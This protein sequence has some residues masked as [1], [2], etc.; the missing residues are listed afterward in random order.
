[1]DHLFQKEE[2]EEERREWLLRQTL[3]TTSISRKVQKYVVVLFLF[4]VAFD[5]VVKIEEFFR[6]KIL[7]LPA[8]KHLPWE[9]L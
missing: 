4:F 5:K 8:S 9:S 1:M 6:T 3:S 7:H 2:E